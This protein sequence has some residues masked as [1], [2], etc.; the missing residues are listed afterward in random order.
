MLLG[1]GLRDCASI[2]TDLSGRAYAPSDIEPLWPIAIN[3]GG[4]SEE[5]KG[6]KE[7][8]RV[9]MREERAR[10]GESPRGET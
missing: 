1:L 5:R 4:A 8:V 6:R 10:E 2:S 7:G 3:P 9:V